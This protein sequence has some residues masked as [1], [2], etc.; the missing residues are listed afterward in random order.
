M[1]IIIAFAESTITPDLAP[2]DPAERIIDS[3]RVD[4]TRMWMFY[5]G[6]KVHYFYDLRW[7][8]GTS[9]D[10][11]VS[12]YFT[13]IPDSWTYKGGDDGMLISYP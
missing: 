9:T 5:I 12:Q 1:A 10:H 6:P 13:H 4:T 2:T 8:L 11:S 3:V 7:E